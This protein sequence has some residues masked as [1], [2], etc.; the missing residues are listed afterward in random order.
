MTFREKLNTIREG[1]LKEALK[2]GSR[3][4][5]TGVGRTANWGE[6]KGT[7]NR[8]S[9]GKVYVTWDGAPH[10]DDEMSPDEVKE[11][12]ESLKESSVQI[13]I[14]EWD[15]GQYYVIAEEYSE[16]RPAPGIHLVMVTAHRMKDGEPTEQTL[17][18]KDFEYKDKAKALAY[19][20]QL[21]K[22]YSA[23][24]P[25]KESFVGKTFDND[26][27]GTLGLPVGTFKVLSKGGDKNVGPWGSFSDLEVQDV[28]TGKKYTIPTGNA[29]MI[30]GLRES[31][32][33]KGV[34]KGKAFEVH[35]DG[36]WYFI[37]VNG[38]QHDIDVKD[39]KAAIAAAKKVIEEGEDSL[40]ERK[41][42]R[43]HEAVSEKDN[44]LAYEIAYDKA[45]DG[46]NQTT[47]ASKLRKAIPS[48]SQDRAMSIAK[49]AIDAWKDEL[50]ASTAKEPTGTRKYKLF[51][52]AASAMAFQQRMGKKADEL[53]KGDD[54]KPAERGKY[55]VYYY[56][57]KLEQLHESVMREASLADITERDFE[58]YE[59]VRKSGKTNMF[60]VGTVEML[61]GLDR[62]TIM[63]IMKHYAALVK[64]Y[65]GVRKEALKGPFKRA[66]G[67]VKT[68][69]KAA[70]IKAAKD[71]LVDLENDGYNYFEA[72]SYLRELINEEL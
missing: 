36:D 49:G 21:V 53:R 45:S 4:T 37:K 32:Y 52:D 23:K 3:V 61:S 55:V 7:V 44:D 8:V 47:I 71:M 59:R 22:K 48:L 50:D 2:K 60:D 69:S 6:Q 9:A 12:K 39:P 17:D 5:T 58:A 10:V 38:T 35:K 29:Q 31:L 42:E 34:H 57:R 16:N 27:A 54:R 30:F 63:A 56:E 19:F 68:S 67:L 62:D 25:K 40:Y 15:N 33:A 46:D 72:K 65:P 43:L 11:L 70:F 18:A 66:D 64:K 26:K 20:E 51:P 14:K 24:G 28:K 13:P 1:V 41:L